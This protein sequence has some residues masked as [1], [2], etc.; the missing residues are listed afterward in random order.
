MRARCSIYGMTVDPA[1]YILRCVI[2][3]S[4]VKD[5]GCGSPT[6]RVTRSGNLKP[7]VSRDVQGVR[8]LP[9]ILES[10]TTQQAVKIAVRRR[11]VSRLDT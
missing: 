2:T 3:Q 10:R 1:E 11:R 4:S 6:Y 7:L 9:E 5:L 8:P